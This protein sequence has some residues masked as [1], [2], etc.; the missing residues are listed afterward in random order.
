VMRVYG[1]CMKLDA[2]SKAHPMNQPGAAA[3]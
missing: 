1:E 2:F 3:H